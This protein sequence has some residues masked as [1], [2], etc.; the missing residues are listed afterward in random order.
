MATPP[1]APYKQRQREQERRL[2]HLYSPQPGE[3]YQD[4]SGRVYLCDPSTGAHQRVG[5]TNPGTLLNRLR[6]QAQFFR[7]VTRTK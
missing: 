6:R 2:A 5:W 4:R 1:N 3:R 7:D